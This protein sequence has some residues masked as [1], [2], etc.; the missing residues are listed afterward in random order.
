MGEGCFLPRSLLGSFLPMRRDMLL[1]T[2]PSAFSSIAPSSSSRVRLVNKV[3][4]C[5][6]TLAE[7]SPVRFHHLLRRMH[8]VGDEAALHPFPSFLDG[9]FPPFNQLVYVS[10]EVGEG[11][12]HVDGIPRG[13]LDV[14]HA[15]S[16][17]QF[18]SLVPG[19]LPLS[20]E[21][22]LVAHQHKDDLVGLDMHFGLF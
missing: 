2:L 7:A 20:V 22:T 17:G 1:T 11:L 3:Q 13:G 10:R 5:F 15:V 18:L 16:D 21:V 19:D 6:S 8:Y 9:D 14:S 12:L 4:H